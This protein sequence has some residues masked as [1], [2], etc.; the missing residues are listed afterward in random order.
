M[1]DE[2]IEVHEEGLSRREL[3]RR[4]VAVAGAVA[5]GGA[6]A[7][8]AGAARSSSGQYTGTIR[9]TG[10]GVDLIDPIKKQAEKDLGFKLEFNATDGPTMVQRGITQPGSFD[11]FSGYQSQIEP[12]WPAGGFQALD[13]RKIK[14]WSQIQALFKKGK[15]QPSA[16]CTVGDGDAAFRN[17]YFDPDKSGKW[18]GSADTVSQLRKEIVVWAD[19]KGSGKTKGPEP[20]WVTN[21]PQNFNFDSIGYNTKVIPVAPEKISWAELFNKKWKGKVALLKDPGVALQDAGF[22]AEASGLMKFKDVGNM[23]KPE[24]DRLMKVM[25]KLKKD[26]QFRAFWLT[27]NESVNLM[28]SG[29]VVLESMWSPAV[30]L[31]Q[32]QQFPVRYAAPPE[33][34]RA[35]AAGEMISSKVTDP[36]KLQACYDYINWWHE[37]KAGATMMRQGYYIAVQQTSRKYVTK[38]EWDFWI[39]G[40]PAP[41]ALADPFGG[42]SIKPGTVRDGGSFLKRSCRIRS[43]NSYFQEGEYLTQR[44]ND[45]LTA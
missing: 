7:G 43:W 18:P 41:T 27:F 26:G 39:M 24:I 28:Q 10:L 14:H 2:P 19:D 42:K 23:T 5:A 35:W 22:A 6:L 17:L 29:E 30:S 3:M 33:G 11:V 44:W 13:S 25:L 45:F 9:V 15:S 1:S 21:V 32:S 36:A 37:G 40:K 12:M 20:R 34:F 4:G 8:S 31:L 38:G 16:R